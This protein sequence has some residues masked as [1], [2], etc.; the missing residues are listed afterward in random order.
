MPLV[1]PDLTS[2]GGGDAKSD[3]MNKLMGKKLT[4]SNTD[5]QVRISDLQ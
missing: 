5:Q 4:D 3:W 1:V 2:K